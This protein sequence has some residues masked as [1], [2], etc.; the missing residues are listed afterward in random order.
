MVTSI[1]IFVPLT[2]FSFP[3]KFSARFKFIS[4]WARFNLWW[5]AV[6]CNLRFEVEGKENIPKEAAII[7]CKHQSMWETLALQVICPAQTWVL[8]RELMRVPLFG[9]GLAMLDPVAIDR[10]SGR[11]ALRQLVEQGKARLDKGRWIVIFPEGTR[12][13]PGKRRAFGFGGAKLAEKSGRLVL[14]I[15]HNAGD[16][17]PRRAFSKYPGVI[18]VKVGPPIQTKGRKAG[19]INEEAELWIASAMTEITGVAEEL[20]KRK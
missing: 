18:K 12:M 3:F 17:W 9:W 11:Q 10:A 6:T 8:K 2:L 7:F 14:P 20:V 13:P 5:L 4:Q 16:F 15:A 1:I 19:D